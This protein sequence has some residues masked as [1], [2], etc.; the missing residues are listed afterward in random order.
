MKEGLKGKIVFIIL[1]IIQAGISFGPCLRQI[2]VV[3]TESFDLAGGGTMSYLPK[4]FVALTAVEI[5]LILIPKH[6]LLRGLG[7][8]LDLLKILAPI[9]VYCAGIVKNMGGPYQAARYVPSYLG[10]GLYALSLVV[11]GF[12]IYEL[13][14]D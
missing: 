9:L 6:K 13:S 14:T 7:L 2:A 4:F 12:Y 3:G 11:L 1:L 10:Y 8:A 5:L